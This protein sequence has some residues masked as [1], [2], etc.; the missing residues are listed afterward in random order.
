MRLPH[1]HLAPRRWF[2]GARR[3]F[4][5]EPLEPRLM[6]AIVQGFKFDDRDGDGA[7]DSGEPGLSGWVIYH[8]ENNNNVR[9]SGEAA[10]TTGG[11]G[12][13]TLVFPAGTGQGGPNPTI[14]VVREVPQTGWRLTAPAGGEH[15]LGLTNTSVVQNNNFLNTQRALLSGVVYHDM[16]I[17]AEFDAGDTP[18]QGW[19]IYVD[20]NRDNTLDPG[21]PRFI[22]GASGSYRFTLAPSTT[23]LVR[24]VP[25]A[26]GWKA[27]EPEFGGQSVTPGTGELLVRNFGLTQRAIVNGVKFND[28]DGD[29]VRDATE[30][31]LANWRVY[32]DLDDDGTLDT[33]E[34]SA[35]SDVDGNFTIN[36][37]AGSHPFREVPQPGWR[38]THP[39]ADIQQN[40]PPGIIV[41]RHFGNTQL[42]L[43]SGRVI[44]DDDADG[45]ADAGEGGQ[46]ARVYL[47]LD[48]DGAFDAAEPNMTT[49]SDGEYA[50]PV[51]YLPSPQTYQVRHVPPAGFRS[52]GPAVHAVTFNAPAQVRPDRDFL[53]TNRQVITGLKYDDQNA[54]GTRDAG[55]PGL[56]GWTVYVDRDNDGVADA[57]EPSAVTD[58]SGNFRF[59][60]PPLP[61]NDPV[62]VT[63]REVGR[64]GWRQTAPGG[65]GAHAF[66]I[67]NG[68][69]VAQRNFGN[70]QAPAPRI[71]NVFARSSSW[72]G[73][74]GNPGNLTFREYLDQAG[75]GH[76]SF[77]YRI[78]AGDV[79]PW[80]N[81]NQ[82]VLR[83]DWPVLTSVLAGQVVVDGVRSDYAATP[84][85]PAGRTVV[86]RLD[87]PLGR[88]PAGGENGD[89]IRLAVAGG[90]AGGA[91]FELRFDV[92]QGDVDGSGSVVANDF[93]G[94]KRKFFRTTNA[95]GPVGDGR[96]SPFHDVDGSG[97]VLADDFSAVK[98]RFFDTL[99]GGPASAAAVP[100]RAALQRRRAATA[101]AELL[102]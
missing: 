42:G 66:E 90:G 6:L 40:L 1:A 71:V 46:A 81:V 64:A 84:D 101:A 78:E 75:I 48:D 91:N 14:E 61:A 97:G 83:Y 86:L 98:A 19:T 22:T 65:T 79:L 62:E 94:V 60:L 82:L 50:F 3:H 54:D 10:A 27:T 36:V 73:D 12:F 69:L 72:A 92:L 68:R 38:P 58:A 53:V 44:R 34:P 8:D 37:P 28:L 77:G 57:G 43:V 76:V 102:A 31:G 45:V 88:L 80:V 96:Y 7:R 47:D 26:G 21:E 32:A 24:A 15:Q 30:P 33:G 23:H 55:E 52:T 29:S 49:A 41:T 2:P 85:A 17:N 89:R 56:P 16:N 74:D 4:R 99:P 13:Y 93:S 63:V 9:N 5:A 39:W 20:E 18:L 100:P 35:V 87:R 11:D 59:V 51:Q 25:Q 95:P 67:A 70:T